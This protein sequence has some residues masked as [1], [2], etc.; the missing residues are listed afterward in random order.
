MRLRTPSMG[1]VPWFLTVAPQDSPEMVPRP[2]VVG[3][4]RASVR[5]RATIVSAPSGFGKT[6][7][8][9]QYAAARCAERPGS[10]S[11][12]TLSDQMIDLWDV[13]RAVVTALRQ[14][15]QD[16]GDSL[17]EG[18]LSVVLEAASFDDAM[19]V[20]AAI[21][22]HQSV[23]VVVDDAQNARDALSDPRFARLVEYGPQWLHLIVVTTDAADPV[24]VRLRAHGR[25]RVLGPAD[26]AF[27]PA[28]IVAAGTRVGLPVDHGAAAEIMS[29]TG[30][31][32][33]AVRLALN[34]G[35][36]SP[37]LA[38]DIDPA[39]YVD[40]A[41]LQ[42]MRPDLA[43]FV[44]SVTVTGRVDERLAQTLSGRADAGAL[45][46]ECIAAGLFIERFQSGGS[47]VYQW[48]S[49]LTTSCQSIL[50]RTDVTRW[51]RL[52][53][54]AARE[55]ADAHPLASVEHAIRA[56]DSELAHAVIFDHWLE[57]LLQSR[58]EALD[59]VC[60]AVMT[61]F[62][63]HP[64]LLM[65]RACCRDLLGDIANAQLLLQRARIAEPGGA[66]SARSAF[67]ADIACILVSADDEEMLAAG[68]RAVAALADRGLVPGPVYAGALFV[69]GWAQSSLR[70]GGL[71]LLEAAV[72]ESEAL[73][74]TELAL[75]ARQTLAFSAVAVGEFERA[76]TVVSELDSVRTGDPELSLVHYWVGIEP[77]TRG[78]A[79]MWRGE[80]DRARADLAAAEAVAGI[81]YP[82][83]ARSLL[84][85][86]AAT[87]GDGMA[88]AAEAVARIHDIDCHG[89]P[90]GIYKLVAGARL[91]EARGER[92]TALAMVRRLGQG[93]NTPA[94]S[95]IASGI[96]RR[97]GEP[98]LA[99]RYA[100]AAVGTELQRYTRVYALVTLAIIDWSRGA[101]SAAHD[102]LED[103]L[104]QAEVERIVYPF[105]DNA[106]AQ[107]LEMLAAHLPVTGYRDF[108]QHCLD[109][110]Y[111]AAGRGVPASMPP[112]T[113]REKEVLAY[114]RTPMTSAE[115][116]EQ[117]SVSVNTLKTH[118]RSL[119]RKLGVVNR[120]DACRAVHR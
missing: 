35:G 116:A 114:L 15:S 111:S 67:V 118:Q 46:A 56:G 78:Y 58:P 75:R 109:A 92:R 49:M 3:K 87:L 105:L 103:A 71:D 30:G 119:Y 11:W 104:A 84:A 68:D 113:R 43:D 40:S 6:V 33:A 42:R 32:P 120:R 54:V 29:A 8:V 4:L 28:D 39:D 106:D 108:L 19:T 81:G 20:L 9:A 12:V 62:G 94:M 98:A 25:V 59:R 45:L 51:E 100:E 76:L 13:L 95:A 110:C 53:A 18:S 24:L 82:D 41:V 90:L 89:A 85:F 101:G 55:L 91:A 34:N 107:C 117:M 86:T 70:R 74:L 23:A 2:T 73:G 48:H 97:L 38:T 16:A 27:A 22:H 99:G 88:E 65:I 80:L 17:L 50:R 21:E 1:R 52:N 93:A 44:L 96:A 7:A 77:L 64:M 115:I 69:L 102:K 60:V 79:R 36:Q 112:L 31:W 26:L 47:T 57:L 61:A 72:T 63:E 37:D 14:A 83:I 5:E 66:L 10:V